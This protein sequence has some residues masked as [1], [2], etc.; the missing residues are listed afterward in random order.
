MCL[1]PFEILI[2]VAR[3][4]AGGRNSQIRIDFHFYFYFYFSFLYSLL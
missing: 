4:P 2:E 1:R 3:E